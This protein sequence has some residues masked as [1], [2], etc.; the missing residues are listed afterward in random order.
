MNILI[1]TNLYPPQELGGYGRSIADFAWGLKKRHHTIQVLSS[2]TPDLGLSTDKGPSGENVDRRLKLKGTYSG[3]VK[4]IEDLS[5]R[6]EIDVHNIQLIR[7]WLN[8]IQW[9]GILLG[10]IDL[11]GPE[12]IPVLLEGNCKIQHHIG[13]VHPP[14]SPSA[15]PASKKYVMVAASKA[16]RTAL[17][18]GGIPTDKIPVIYPGARTE[19]FGAGITGMPAPLPSDGSPTRPLKVC[20]AG[21]LMAS[22][23]S[24]Q[25]SKR[26]YNSTKWNLRT[27]VNCW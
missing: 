25:W 3:G 9:D 1:V 22:K 26:L 13:F 17:I 2:D 11:L 5:K 16:V 20:F 10:N 4:H 23:G 8:T 27:G 18:N 14:F 15:W 7:Y 24:T 19:Q 12:L 21:L 6:R